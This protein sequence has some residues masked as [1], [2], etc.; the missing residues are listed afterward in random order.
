MDPTPSL[1]SSLDDECGK[2]VLKK[3]KRMGRARY[4][5]NKRKKRL[6]VQYGVAAILAL[7]AVVVFAILYSF[8]QYDPSLFY[9]STSYL[10]GYGFI[11][12]A[13]GLIGSY[14]AASLIW[15][16]GLAAYLLIPVCL[17]MAY[18]MTMYTDGNWLKNEWDRVIA[19]LL[20]LP[21]VSAFLYVYHVGNVS[22]F[23]NGGVAGQSFYIFLRV[24]SLDHRA[25]IIALYALLFSLTIVLLR[26]SLMSIAQLI[27]SG[28]KKIIA[29]WRIWA[30]PVIIFIEALKQTALTCIKILGRCAH[31]LIYPDVSAPKVHDEMHPALRLKY[32][33]LQEQ[34]VQE[35]HNN[36]E[37]SEQQQVPITPVEKPLVKS[38]QK[39]TYELPDKIIL[40]VSA[41]KAEAVYTQEH[42]QLTKVLEEKLARFGVVGTVVAVKPG[43]VITLFEYQP[44]ID[45]K[46]SKITA[47]EHD[48]T[49]AL[50]AM[51]VRIIAPIP[52][53]SRV[54]F[55]VANKHRSVVLMGDVAQ[56]SLFAKAQGT[57]NFIVGK[58][59][60]G[61]DV[62]V[63][64]ADMPHLLIAGSTGSGKSVALNTMLTSWLYTCTPDQ[65]RLIII[66]P[67]R[68]E[69]AAYHDIPHLLFPI[70][71]QA[72][73]AGPVVKWL[74]RTM[75][76]RYEKMAQLGMR[77]ITD[78]KKM[79]AEKKIKDE[80]PFIVLMIDELA[81]LM[82]VSRKEIEESI[83][84]LA[85]MARA[86]GI[87]LVVATQRPSVDVL[88]GLIK[89]NFPSRI[90]FRVT[91]KIDSRTI[92]DT[93]GAET[94]LGKGDMLFMDAQS[95]R[96]KRIHGAYVSDAEINAT[97]A[98]VRMQQ[99]VEYIDIQEVIANHSQ[100][101][102]QQDDPLLQEVVSFLQTLE[103]VSI[104][105]LQ[106]RFKIGYNRS[107]RIIE[108]LE[109]QGRVMPAEGARA[110]KIVK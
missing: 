77:N 53:T 101:L 26:M 85:Q 89:V 22:Y 18:G 6:Y 97:V 65:L 27:V 31:A 78:Y 93:F 70:V 58:D 51:S 103:E 20:L 37:S 102:N 47:L 109:M 41:R 4:H 110:R 80:L 86:A 40:K 36:A 88:T 60:S 67:K 14:A 66:D 24:L 56:S 74:V 84:R 90:S 39:T 17:L 81:D 76:E 32:Q 23:I 16:F 57:L 62:I 105:L 100:H 49:L 71:T 7:A 29:H 35:V 1:R 96:L 69:F 8:D 15:F 104:S 33:E 43:P 19:A 92:L 75:E 106:R 79:C 42:K 61:D 72:H 91:S 52:G 108:L 25:V 48:L 95:S 87:H 21:V 11:S 9:S 73:K 12:N 59:T 30:K 38:L 2:L 98:H 5:E 55:E 64:L 44:A 68:L 83:A 28:I 13:G 50:E 10:D 34:A 94:L 63:D 99:A 107:A 54:G 3:G 82:M 45:T 46:I